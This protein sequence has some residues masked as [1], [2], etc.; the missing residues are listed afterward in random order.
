MMYFQLVNKLDT[1]HNLDIGCNIFTL[2]NLWYNT[3]IY[4]SYYITLI[5][6]DKVICL[7]VVIF[8]M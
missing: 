8:H 5:L 4:I 7:D 2:H 6:Y 3:V 1:I